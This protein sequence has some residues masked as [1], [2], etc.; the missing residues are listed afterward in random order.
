M[1]QYFT[2]EQGSLLLRFEITDSFQTLLL[3]V[4]P[5]GKQPVPVAEDSKGWFTPVELQLTGDTTLQTTGYKHNGTKAGLEL[6]YDDRDE[7][8]NNHGRKV[9]IH[10][11]SSSGLYVTSHIQFYADTPVVRCWTQLDN[12]GAQEV[13]LEYVSSFVYHG[14]AK[15]GKQPY[16]DK[17]TLWIP[18]SCWYGECRWVEQPVSQVGLTRLPIHGQGCFGHSFNRFSYGSHGSWSSCDYLPMGMIQDKEEG[19]T[20]FWQIESGGPWLAEYGATPGGYLYVA[21]S[22]PTEAEDHWW[23]NLKPGQSFT[24][25]PA[26]FGVVEGDT[27]AAL[28]ALNQYRRDM[29]RLNED[30]AKC[31]VVF[32]DYMNCLMGDPTEETLLPMIDRAAELGCEYYCIDCGWYADGYWWDSIGEW[33]VSK[34]RFPGGIQKV[35][36]YIHQ[37]GMKAGI[38]LEIEGMGMNCPLAKTLP[39]DWFFCR[40]GKRVAQNQRYLLDFRNPAV[41]DYVSGIVEPM[42][43]DWGVD[44]FKMDYNVNTGIGSDINSD[45]CGDALL[46]HIRAVQD[47]YRYLYTRYPFLVIENCGSGGQRMDYGFLQLHSLQSISDQT[48]YISNAYIASVIASAVTPEQSGCWV[49]PYEDDPEHVIFCMVTGL[50]LRPYISGKVW[51]LSQPQLDLMAQGIALYKEKIRRRLIRATPFFPL[52]LSRENDPVLAFGV[53]DAN[54]GFVAVFGIDQDV[55]TLNLPTKK[56]IKRVKCI[57]PDSED[58]RYSVYQQKLTVALPQ[59]KC[60]RLFEFFY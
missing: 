54:G 60:A 59:K 6:E 49:Y 44:F 7:Y 38:W 57:Y 50:L 16:Y 20:W 35:I 47:W 27:Q 46:E 1:A 42:I 21:L 52:G 56:P 55:M 9:E 30:A 11:T 19:L 24:T 23:K 36:D 17:T 39:D 26:A 51:Q 12:Q 53:E 10:Y 40:H 32:N 34:K 43:V 13:G 45:S 25:V 2:L 58:C 33:Q 8:A 14:L 3:E 31:N 29:R 48:D 18:Y 37:K 28:Q 41:L 22:G 15:E 5:R 4:S